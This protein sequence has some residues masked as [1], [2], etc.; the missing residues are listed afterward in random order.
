MITANTDTA[1]H[2]PN[3]VEHLPPAEPP[4][5]RTYTP[6]RTP[7]GFRRQ[8]ATLRRVEP[9]A[10]VDDDT[11]ARRG[12]KQRAV[13][14]ALMLLMFRMVWSLNLAGTVAAAVLVGRNVNTLLIGAG[15]TPL[16]DIDYALVAAAYQLFITHIQQYLWRTGQTYSGP[17]VEQ[18]RTFWRDLDKTKLSLVV[19]FGVTD[20]LPTAWFVLRGSTYVWDNSPWALPYLLAAGL[21]VPMAMLVEPAMTKHRRAMKRLFASLGYSTEWM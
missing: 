10:P 11:E 2:N 18:A 5:A 1:S 9:L 17:L 4:R 6:Q 16:G 7:L 20:A 3:R 8:A 12:I 15:L 19:F 14:E 13:A 21:A